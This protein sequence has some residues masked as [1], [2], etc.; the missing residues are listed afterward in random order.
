MKHLSLF[1]CVFFFAAILAAQESDPEQMLKQIEQQIRFMNSPRAA[2]QNEADYR[3]ISPYDGQGTWQAMKIISQAGG[4]EDLGLTDEQVAALPFLQHENEITREYFQRMRQQPSEEFM[5]AAQTIQAA[6]P[7]DDPFFEKATDEQKQAFVE[8]NTDFLMLSVK[9]LERQIDATLTPEQMLQVR[10]LEM[11]LMPE[12]GMPYPSMFDV[13]DLSE[14]QK[15]EMRKIAD[16]MKPEYEKLLSESAALRY[17]RLYRSRQATFEQHR[18]KPFTSIQDFRQAINQALK[19][20]K[21]DAEKYNRLQEKGIQFT[22]RLKGRLMNV[23]TDEQL[24]KMQKIMDET[25]EWAKKVLAEMQKQREQM[26]KSDQYM[27]GP[28]S[29]RPGDGTPKEFKE[30]R[31]KKP[32]PTGE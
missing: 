19:T 10:K 18:Q 29:W 20:V 12:F 15:K 24:D 6:T 22:T 31:Q 27:P 32:F 2:L 3:C 16:E 9:D 25:P 28:E 26:A 8:A 7:Q 14:E 1:L 17:D 11:Q 13:L 23:L 30:Q 4:Q 21:P 5:Q